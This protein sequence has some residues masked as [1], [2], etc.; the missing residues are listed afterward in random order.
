[1]YAL[2]QRALVTQLRRDGPRILSV[3]KCA[4][5][6]MNH[7]SF[8]VSLSRALSLG[9]PAH[10]NINTSTRTGHCSGNWLWTRLRVLRYCTT[11]VHASIHAC[12]YAQHIIIL[13]MLAKK[14]RVLFCA[15]TTRRTITRH[16][17]RWH[18]Q[19]AGQHAD[20]SQRVRS[21]PV[22]RLWVSWSTGR[23]IWCLR[24]ISLCG[25][26]T[27]EFGDWPRRRPTVVTASNIW[28]LAIVHSLTQS[29][30]NY[31]INHIQ[32]RPQRDRRVCVCVQ[33]HFALLANQ[34]KAAP[35]L[36]N[37]SSSAHTHTAIRPKLSRSSN[38]SIS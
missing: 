24:R 36:A 17:H 14:Q 34:K 2:P 30:R 35:F 12:L 38:A 9:R 33:R 13:F 21:V 22:P 19:C 7:L 6:C 37:F 27:G 10:I 23:R 15:R 26:D 18:S 29:T 11:R 4:I 3:S 31:T 5:F 28:Y 16:R 25:S 1:M 8:T 20:D 32:W